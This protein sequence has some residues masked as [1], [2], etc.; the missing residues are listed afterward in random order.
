MRIKEGGVFNMGDASLRL[1]KQT[2]VYRI[3]LELLNQFYKDHPDCV[4]SGDRVVQEEFY[5]YALGEITRMEK[6]EG[7]DIFGDLERVYHVPDTSKLGQRG[8]AW[9][10]ALVKNGLVNDERVISPVGKPYLSNSNAPP[11]EL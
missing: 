2:R 8:R 5:E 9:T 10:S 11:D 6:E 4:F 1:R 3:L 7:A